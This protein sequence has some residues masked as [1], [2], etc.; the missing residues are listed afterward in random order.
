M[1]VACAADAEQLSIVP[2]VYP[3][4]I[5]LSKSAEVDTEVNVPPPTH[6]HDEI[7][8]AVSCFIPAIAD[9]MVDDSTPDGTYMLKKCGNHKSSTHRK[10]VITS[11]YH[12]GCFG[13]TASDGSKPIFVHRNELSTERN[14][15]Q[16]GANVE[17]NV[18]FGQHK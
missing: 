17:Y 6:M 1:A 18:V 7:N 5:A 8:P 13:I 11:D 16:V 3:A 15:F 4:F 14:Y 10:G 2:T 9:D 12:E